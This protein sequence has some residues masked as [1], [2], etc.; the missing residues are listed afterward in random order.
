[1]ATPTGLNNIPTADVVPEQ[2]LVFQAFGNFSGSTRPDVWAGFKYGL[3]TNL[4]IGF[5]GQVN[6]DPSDEGA[7]AGQANYRFT[8][9]DSSALGVGV[10]NI[11]DEDRNGEVDYYA[12]F[13]QD[14]GAV[15]LHLGGTLQQDNEGIFAG[16]DTTWPVFERDFTFRSDIRQTEERDEQLGSAGFIYDLGMNMLL[17]AWGSFPSR[18]GDE[19]VATVKLNYVIVF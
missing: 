2:T 3:L 13:S 7:L 19:D 15:R 14:L 1:V 9:G 4:E 12:V 16:L 10:A 17:E 11:G 6:P 18:G 5:D 8:I